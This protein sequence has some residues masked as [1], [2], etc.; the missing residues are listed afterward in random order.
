L[1][2]GKALYSSHQFF[3]DTDTLGSRFFVLNF[4][5]NKILCA[6]NFG[7]CP[8]FAPFFC[9]ESY[10]NGGL[11]GAVRLEHP[12]GG[13]GIS[14][15]SATPR[16]ILSVTNTGEC[17]THEEGKVGVQIPPYTRLLAL[18]NKKI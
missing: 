5:L 2:L 12:P 7:S 18:K 4:N 10:L 17:W 13:G 8:V 15:I 6:T 14:Q 9:N 1:F 11:T 3:L 16:H